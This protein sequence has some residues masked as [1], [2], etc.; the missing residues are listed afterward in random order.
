MLFGL[1]WVAS[2]GGRRRRGLASQEKE[3][4]TE[5]GSLPAFGRGSGRAFYQCVFLL[6]SLGGW[7]GGGL[8]KGGLEMRPMAFQE[9]GGLARKRGGI[10]WRVR[11]EKAF[12][13]IVSYITV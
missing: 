12:E 10:R 8:E 1:G 5:A 2:G 13:M 7:E 6:F 3:A 4:A 11:E 9:G